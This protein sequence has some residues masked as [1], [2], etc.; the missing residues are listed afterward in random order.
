MAAAEVAAAG[1]LLAAMAAAAT[2]AAVRAAVAVAVAV[3]AAVAMTVV[4]MPSTRTA[5][6]SMGPR[7]PQRLLENSTCRR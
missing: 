3:K 5:G 2:V 7:N 4:T 6:G 1:M